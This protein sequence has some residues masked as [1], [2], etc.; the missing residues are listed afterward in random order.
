[1]P[2][3]D[4]FRKAQSG[5]DTDIPSTLSLRATEVPPKV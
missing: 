4:K 5:K 3:K 1:M 2:S